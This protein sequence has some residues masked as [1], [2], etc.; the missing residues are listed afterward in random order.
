M[1]KSKIKRRRT[2]SKVIQ[3]GSTVFY[4]G[5]DE[6]IMLTSVLTKSFLTNKS[7]S[8]IIKD[9]KDISHDLG[10]KYFVIS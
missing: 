4:H 1:R 3:E 10:A 7:R 2:S 6:K 5:H 8:H 9:L